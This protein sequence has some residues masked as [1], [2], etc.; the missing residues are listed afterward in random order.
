[1]ATVK[2]VSYDTAFRVHNKQAR[3]TF[4][5][6]VLNSHFIQSSECKYVLF[7]CLSVRLQVSFI[8]LRFRDFDDRLSF[9]TVELSR[10]S[11]VVPP[12]R[13]NSWKR[14]NIIFCGPC[15]PLGADRKN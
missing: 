1:M 12:T 14:I 13:Q 9:R 11:R 5:C 10:E 15:R 3:Q 7:V 8:P 2:Q 6:F 4:H